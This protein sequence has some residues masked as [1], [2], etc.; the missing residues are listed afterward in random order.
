MNNR[1]ITL[2]EILAVLTIV[3]LLIAL[4]APSFGSLRAR[5]NN[6]AALSAISS[7]GKVFS[8]YQVDHAGTYPF[9]VAPGASA[10]T[11]FVSGRPYAINGHFGQIYVW[12]F[13][14]ASAYYE[15]Q[16]RGELFTRPGRDAELISD[17]RYS[18]SFIA[19]PGFWNYGNRGPWQWRSQR[20]FIVRFP[21]SKVLFADDRVME[22]TADSSDPGVVCLVDL[23][24]RMVVDLDLERPFPPGEGNWPGT[25]N[26]RGR[27]GIHTVDGILGKDIK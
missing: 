20:D 9:L 7:H 8:L 2:I 1:G 6:I 10:S 16:V 18:A 12:Q 19:D 21:S 17:Y 15:S 14:L 27:P 3:V 13:G 11:Y 22:Q 4:L 25:F 5:A 26:S 24:A 23:S